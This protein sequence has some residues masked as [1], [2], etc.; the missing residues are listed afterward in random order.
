MAKASGGRG[1]GV[2]VGPHGTEW[3]V[4]RSGNARASAV[5]DTQAEAI[6]SLGDTPIRIRQSSWC[7]TGTDRSGPK[8]ARATSPPSTTRTER[9]VSQHF[10]SNCEVTRD[11]LGQTTVHK[12]CA[13]CISTEE[14]DRGGHADAPQPNDCWI[15]DVETLKL[16]TSSR[17]A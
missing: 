7:R 8:T 4:K 1:R 5:V 9:A 10:C 11:A 16:T 6:R 2:F 15:C 14:H 12:P 13:G 3:Q 17:A